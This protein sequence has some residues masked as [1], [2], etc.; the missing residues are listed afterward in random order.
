ML[1]AKTCQIVSLRPAKP[2]ICVKNVLEAV[3]AN[4]VVSNTVA[5]SLLCLIGELG[6]GPLLDVPALTVNADDPHVLTA[7][8]AWNVANV[9]QLE[10][11]C[12]RAARTDI[13]SI[14]LRRVTALDTVGA[15]LLERLARGGATRAALTGADGPYGDLLE[16]VRELNRS[17][18]A[19]R[20]SVN[21]LLAKLDQLGRGSR[22]LATDSTALLH[23][24]GAISMALLGV[25]RHPRSFRLTSTVYQLGRV[26]WHAVPIMALITLLIAAIIAQQGIVHFSR[27]G[28]ES[29]VVD[30]VGILVLREIG[31]LIVA[32]MVA[33]DRAAP[34]RLR[35]AR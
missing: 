24:L 13:G 30:M 28:A 17:V 32:I 6:V 21:P 9:E 31:V 2:L 26:G 1:S 10:Q 23:M 29:Y 5:A 3:E 35:S 34:I 4:C 27:F 20:G 15:W 11:L 33:G 12:E 18:P 25:L 7:C 8:G 22:R 19:E 16:E 14:D